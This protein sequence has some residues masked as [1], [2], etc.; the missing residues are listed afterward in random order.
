MVVDK[1]IINTK[2][3]TYT[4]KNNKYK[5]NIIYKIKIYLFKNI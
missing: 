1:N 3:F 2:I 5:I 4:F